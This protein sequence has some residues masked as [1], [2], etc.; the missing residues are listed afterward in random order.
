MGKQIQLY[1]IPEDIA[2]FEE[3]LRSNDIAIIR[4]YSLDPRP[5][6]SD[7]IVVKATET[8]GADGFLVRHGDI[9]DVGLQYVPER[10][11]WVVDG[12]RS[13]VIEFFGCNFDGKTLKRGRL[14]Y[15]T[16]FYEISGLR[17]EKPKTFQNWAMD[18]FKLARKM[19]MKDEKLGAYIGENTSQWQS[20]A[21]GILV[22]V[23]FVQ[24]RDAGT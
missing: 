22:S 23:S 21:H 24:P 14:F 13:P 18:V 7:T 1:L 5:V 17:V 8:V 6:I 15:E 3:K 16:G 9:G 2:L 10:A 19:F 4:R 11:H 20:E 12:L